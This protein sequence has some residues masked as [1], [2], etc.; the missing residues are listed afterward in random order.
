[1]AWN[2]HQPEKMVGRLLKHKQEDELES[3][4]TADKAAPD[5]LGRGER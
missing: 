3:E 2:S 5:T 4:L 1:M